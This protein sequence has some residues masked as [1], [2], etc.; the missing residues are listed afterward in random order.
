MRYLVTAMMLVLALVFLASPVLAAGWD[1][2]ALF[3]GDN[4][5]LPG[6]VCDWHTN[7]IGE[8]TLAQVSLRLSGHVVQDAGWSFYVDEEEPSQWRANFNAS[9]LLLDKEEAPVYVSREQE[10]SIRRGPVY[11][12]TY[13]KLDDS[14]DY[15][16]SE[17][18]E[19][20]YQDVLGK[21]SLTPAAVY[22]AYFNYDEYPGLIG[23]SDKTR[24][25]ADF[26]LRG[27]FLDTKKEAEAMGAQFT[28]PEPTTICLLGLGAAGMFFRRRH[29]T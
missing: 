18:N 13:T 7:N 10:S 9:G 2:E 12:T 23:P 8:K 3:L 5:R 14:V 4:V 25:F 20:F 21:F 22:S 24:W 11:L 1:P 6:V 26:S 17:E 19:T 29:K 16:W 15:W 28:T 27:S